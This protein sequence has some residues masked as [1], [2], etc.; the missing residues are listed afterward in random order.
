MLRRHAR[1]ELC[2]ALI[3]MRMRPLQAWQL[4]PAAEISDGTHK[5]AEQ[6][7]RKVII[8]VHGPFFNAEV[9]RRRGQRNGGRNG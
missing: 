9:R 7:V 8:E 5:S 3:M 2:A 4:D 6:V 1:V